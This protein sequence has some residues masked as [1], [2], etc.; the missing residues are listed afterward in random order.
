MDL[1]GQVKTTQSADRSLIRDR[2]YAASSHPL[3]QRHASRLPS[4]ALKH[5]TLSGLSPRG[6]HNRDNSPEVSG[7]SGGRRPSLSESQ[8]YQP[9]VYRSSHLQHAANGTYYSSPLRESNDA[10]DQGPSPQGVGAEGT[11]STVSTTAPSTVWDELDDLKSRLRRLEYTGKLPLSSTGMMPSSTERPRTATTT[12]TTMSS[13]PKR[14]RGA[15]ISPVTSSLGLEEGSVYPLLNRALSQSE[16]FLSTDAYLALTE[17]ASNVLGLVKYAH[18]ASI[19]SSVPGATDR[20]LKIRAETLCRN[21][22]ELCIALTGTKPDVGSNA[23]RPGSRDAST[24]RRQRES[25][26][27]DTRFQRAVSLD[28]EPTTSARV[29]SRLEARRTSILHNSS[30]DSGNNSPAREQFPEATTPTQATLNRT[31][32]MLQRLRR[33]NADDETESTIRPLSRAMTELSR[34]RPSTAAAAAAAKRRSREYTSQHPLPSPESRSPAA[35]LAL[36]AR[37]TFL[38]GG[39]QQP[40]TPSTPTATTTRRYL[41]RVPAEGLKLAEPR[42]QRLTSLGQSFLS[43]RTPASATVIGRYERR[44]PGVAGGYSHQVAE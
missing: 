28:P 6:L 11:E 22:T 5:G 43:S 9:R 16:P 7:S 19:Q 34:A 40:A 25:S 2:P 10:F 12:V 39:L 32:T 4:S 26:V 42:Q 3:D 37:R 30:R 36:P 35:Q 31:A 29:L 38:H 33:N 17:T 44:A 14:A 15:S 27:D 20:E 41:D 8:N 1:R 24:L 13:S 21:L 23:P 18:S